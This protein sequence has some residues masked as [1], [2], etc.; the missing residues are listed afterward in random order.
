[1]YGAWDSRKRTTFRQGEL[2]ISQGVTK[3]FLLIS[4]RKYRKLPVEIVKRGFY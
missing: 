1:M 3:P 2:Y 4:N